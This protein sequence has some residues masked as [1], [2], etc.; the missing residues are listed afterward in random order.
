MVFAI[1]AVTT[2][3]KTM[4]DFKQ[5][6]IK[7]N[8]TDLVAG[9]LQSVDPNAAAAPTTVT[10]AAGAT[11]SGTATSALATA[12]VVAGAGQD[13]QGQACTC[14]CLCGVASFPETAAISNFGGFPGMIA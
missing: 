3:N 6:A 10:I 11:A 8:G 14:Q 13:G 1:N 12:S 5:L 7:T 2:G 9:A 4:A